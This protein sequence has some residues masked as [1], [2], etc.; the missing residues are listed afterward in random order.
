M[1]YTHFLPFGHGTPPAQG[2]LRAEPEDFQVDEDIG[3]EPS[4]AGEHVLL[5]IRKR[6]ANTEW[7]AR[8]IAQVAQVRAA[9][10]SYAGMKDRNAVTSQWFS[11]HLPGREDPDW[12]TMNCT[13]IALLDATRHHRKLRRGALRGNRFELVIRQL[14]GDPAEI[15]ARLQQI[16]VAGVPGYFGAQ[17]FGRDGGNVERA[18]AMFGGARVSRHERGVLLSAARSWLFNKV[19]AERVRRGEW[20]RLMDGDVAMLD[21]SHSVFSA[22]SVDAV[23]TDRCARLDVHPTG[24]LWGRGALASAG[25]VL[26]LEQSVSADDEALCDGL[27]RAGLQQQRR[28]LRHAVRDLQWH[29]QGQSDLRVQFFLDRGNY[30]TSVMRELLGDGPDLDY[31]ITDA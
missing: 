9:A 7:V 19:L 15:E 3:F 11:V 24:P 10:V 2:L 30:A 16:S 1:S 12:S 23:L 13:E 29:W 28:A 31:G 20:E 17:R 6:G 25:Q 5:R 21:G 8:R 27:E 18:R 22:A 14:Q 4:G 26:V